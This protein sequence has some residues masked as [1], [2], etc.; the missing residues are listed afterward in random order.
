MGV[1]IAEYFG[2]R[3]DVDIPI[4]DPINKKA[5][6]PFSSSNICKKLKSGNP[7]VCSV[8]KAD[9]TL[10]IV[11]SDRLCATKK[12]IPLCR[13]Q[14]QILHKIA[15]HLFNPG[16]TLDEVCVKREER[17]DVVEGTKYNADYI[18]SLITGRTEFSGPDRMVLEMQGGGETSNTGKITELINTWQLNPKRTNEIL[19]TETGA[20]TLETNAWRRQQEQFIVK[21][22][23]AMKTWKGYGIAFCVGTLLY[24]YLMNK[25]ATANLPDLKEYNW[26]LAILAIKEDDTEAKSPGPIPLTV[27]ESRMLFTNYQ[28]FVQALINQGEPSLNAFRGTFVNLNN[29]EVNII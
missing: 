26:T 23:I 20:S 5:E 2:Q 17:L 22:N 28:T 19:R 9:G 10:W 25:L 15:Q 13:H 7:P 18:I 16:V 3:T 11:C 14:I 4:I 21:G 6:C 12:D 29:R 24:D 8:R 27:D 1:R